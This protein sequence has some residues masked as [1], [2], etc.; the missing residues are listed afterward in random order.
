MLASERRVF[1]MECL[2]KSNIVSLKDI[3]AQLGTS[4]ITVRRDFEK[5]EAAGKL[6]RVH[7]GAALEDYLDNAELTMSSKQAINRD[8]KARVARRAAQLVRPGDCVFLDGGTSIA[9]LTDYLADLPIDIVTYNELVV[10][11]LV[12]PV[13]RIHVVGGIFL[14]HY[15]MNVGPD[16]QHALG[17]FHFDIGFFGC[18]SVEPETGMTYTTNIDSLNMKHIAL[19]SSAKKY[20]LIDASKLNRSSFLKFTE[21]DKFDRVF[22]D[23]PDPPFVHERF[24]FVE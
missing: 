19:R 6:K 15:T 23:T 13:A 21:L 24:E 17:R 2:N 3:A 9:E 16:A 11:K 20:L 12:N 1:I 5:L 14:P 18:S 4:E 10:R 22:C 7:G 8:E